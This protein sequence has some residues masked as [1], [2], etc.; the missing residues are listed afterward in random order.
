VAGA[1]RDGTE[2]WSVP[3]SIDFNDQKRAKTLSGRV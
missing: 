1:V 3:L 2:A